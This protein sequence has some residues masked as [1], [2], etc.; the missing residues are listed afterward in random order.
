VSRVPFSIK[1]YSL[2]SP[3]PPM[4]SD[5]FFGSLLSC[6]TSI[7]EMSL[8]CRRLLLCSHSLQQKVHSKLE[9]KS[10]THTSSS[11][12]KAADGSSQPSSSSNQQQ[13]MQD[14]QQQ[15]QQQQQHKG[16]P[17]PVFISDKELDQLVQPH[18][19]WVDVGCFTASTYTKGWG[20]GGFGG[21]GV[22]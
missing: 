9:R 13:H 12:S 21:G 22:G 2:V 16:L 19:R 10:A 11:S 18:S 17:L 15:D 20:W 5:R 3:L 1:E 8:L 6:L 4:N 14:R 7:L